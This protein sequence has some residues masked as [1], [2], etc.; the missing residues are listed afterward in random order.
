LLLDHSTEGG[1]M[2]LELEALVAL[3]H[4]QGLAGM[5]QPYMKANCG[6]K[7]ACVLNNTYFLLA[8]YF[9][10]LSSNKFNGSIPRSIC[11]ATKLV[12]LDLSDKLLS[13]TIPQCL[14]KMIREA[15]S[16]RPTLSSRNQGVPLMSNRG[17]G[18][19]NLCRNN[20][21][22][23]IPNVFP[24]NCGL[25]TLNLNGN[26]LEGKL[27]KSLAQC[28]SL[29]VLD[30]GNNHI[31]D[32]FPCYLKKISMLHVLVLRSNKFY[33]PI[34]CRELNASLSELQIVDLAVNNFTGKL[35]IK[36]FSIGRQ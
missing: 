8:T 23:T 32:A 12:V 3:E 33:G 26:Q 29:E 9:F 36:H 10:S 25:Q 28:T 11:Y 18:V 22:G 24:S 14:F 31:E 20:L 34:D 4:Q 1:E 16:L 17:L 30:L 2:T 19:L 13:D 15:Q 27:P 35:P 7:W 6:L 5:G 21:I